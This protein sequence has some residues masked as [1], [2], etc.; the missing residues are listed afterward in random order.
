MGDVAYLQD[1]GNQIKVVYKDGSSNLAYPSTG[2]LWYVSG[3]SGGGTIPDPGPGPSGVLIYPT[4]VHQVSDSFQDHVNRGSVNPGTDYVDPIGNAVRAVH[5]GVVT[6]T[7]TTIGGS[8]GRMV[9]ID[10]TDINT[11]SDYLHLS[12]IDVTVGQHVKQGQQI[13]L[14]GA[15]GLGSENGYGA[16]LHISYR[17]ALGHA[18]TNFNSVDFDA[19]IKAQ[20]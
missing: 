9:H 17:N 4:D 6:D 5:D 1:F 18:Y 11:G 10:H 16:H 14:S 19:L 2:G 3:L 15:S 7:T 20:G 8:G 13:A 12:R